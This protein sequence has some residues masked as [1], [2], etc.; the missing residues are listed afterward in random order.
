MFLAHAGKNVN[1][2]YNLESKEQ[3]DWTHHGKLQHVA[4]AREWAFPPRLAGP[5]GFRIHRQSLLSRLDDQIQRRLRKG[6]KKDNSILER[7]VMRLY[8]K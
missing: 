5:T 1:S 4:L 7:E 2:T 6:W 3:I 8:A